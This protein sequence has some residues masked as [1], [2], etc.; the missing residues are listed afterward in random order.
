MNFSEFRCWAFAAGAAVVTLAGCGGSRN[1]IGMPDTMPERGRGGPS[2]SLPISSRPFT[3]SVSFT[4][5]VSFDSKDGALPNAGLTVV[6]G[7][8]YGTTE[9]GGNS[10][11]FSYETE[12]GCGTVFKVTPAGQLTAIYSFKGSPDG[13][14]PFAPVTNVNGTL[15]GTTAKGGNSG[16]GA[17]S[18]PSGCGTVFKITQSGKESVLHSFAGGSDG[19]VPAWTPLIYVKGALYG[20]TEAGGPND[21]GTIFKITPSGKETIVYTFKGGPEDSRP[22]GIA[23]ANGSFYGPASPSCR[24]D[25]CHGFIYKLTMSGKES[26]LYKFKGLPDG[27]SPMGALATIG[28]SFY[29]TT[30]AGGRSGCGSTGCGTVFELSPA[31]KER[32]LYRFEYPGDPGVTPYAGVIAMQGALYGTACCGGGSVFKVTTAGKEAVLHA[33][34]GYNKNGTAPYGTMTSIDD[35]LYGTTGFGGDK[36]GFK[37]GYGTVFSLT[38]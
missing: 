29:G 1:Q 36:K 4:H 6:G 2:T 17:S 22:T 15:Y 25:S 11:C 38:L 9:L 23:Y 3:S 33:F 26:I 12:N 28:G 35:V 8:L 7:M 21:A 32:V 10:G 27:A 37:Y 5:L 24:Y 16:C 31:G 14:F 34:K 30:A 18:A 19:R 20:V 13:S